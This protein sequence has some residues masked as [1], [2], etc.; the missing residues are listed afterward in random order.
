MTASPGTNPREITDR[1]F[2]LAAER[3][4]PIRDVPAPDGP[5]CRAN[6]SGHGGII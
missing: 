3:L 4:G 2:S 1:N 5:S 6:G